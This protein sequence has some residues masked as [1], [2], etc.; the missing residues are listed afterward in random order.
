MT[1]VDVAVRTFQNVARS[2]RHGDALLQK[3]YAQVENLD[4][5]EFAEYVKRTA[6]VEV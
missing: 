5:L 6:V 1:R 3:L 2:D 4:D